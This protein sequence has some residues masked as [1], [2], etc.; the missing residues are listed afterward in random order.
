MQTTTPRAGC[1]TSGTCRDPASRISPVRW[2]VDRLLPRRGGGWR[3]RDDP[4][5][6]RR[7][8]LQDEVDYWGNWLA[9]GGGKYP[10]DYAHRVDPEAEVDDPAL[11]EVLAGISGQAVSI[12]D[13]GAGPLSAVGYRF[14][15]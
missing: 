5:R 1:S 12:L 9:T 4:V 14:P 11:R 8:A 15:G 7:R 2:S 6:G 3:R 13:V 10:Q